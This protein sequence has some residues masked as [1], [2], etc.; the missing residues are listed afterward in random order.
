MFSALQQSWMQ[1]NGDEDSQESKG[2]KEKKIQ[3]TEPEDILIYEPSENITGKS[4]T[5][6][7]ESVENENLDKEK[8]FVIKNK[9]KACRILINEIKITAIIG[10]LSRLEQKQNTLPRIE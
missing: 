9:N 5:Q 3:I 2:S 1:K 7:K 6:L 10:L 4:R 8:G